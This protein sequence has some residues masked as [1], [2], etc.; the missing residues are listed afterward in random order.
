[1]MTG[2]NL[3]TEE[4]FAQ[5]KQQSFS[6][7]APTAVRF[8]RGLWSGCCSAESGHMLPQERPT[9]R[10]QDGVWPVKQP[11]YASVCF[12]C[13]KQAVAAAAMVEAVR[14]GRSSA[15][16]PSGC[17]HVTLKAL[18]W[19]NEWLSCQL[20]SFICTY[21]FCSLPINTIHLSH[22][23]SLLADGRSCLWEKFAWFIFSDVKIVTFFHVT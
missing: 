6:K 16:W 5:C 10:R 2:F 21:Y 8:I 1:M 17:R 14:R 15:E 19:I 11:F 22:F 12:C 13:C 23:L 4:L 18:C 7:N 3:L 20:L 9:T